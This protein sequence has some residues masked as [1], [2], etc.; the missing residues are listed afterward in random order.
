MYDS[1]VVLGVDIGGSHITAGLVDMHCRQVLQASI[2]RNPVDSHGGQ[3]DILSTWSKTI[4]LAMARSS[5]PIT[6]IGFAMPGPFDYANGICLIDGFDKY[7]SLYGLNIFHQIKKYLNLSEIE[8]LLRNDAEAFLAGELFAG[9]AGE[10]ETAIGITLGT[11]LGSAFYRA[12]ET[13]DAALSVMPYKGDKIEE[14][15]STRGLLRTY[16]ELSGVWL[17]DAKSISDR[18][19][20]DKNAMETYRIFSEDLGWF[21]SRFILNE[22]PEAL[23]IGGNIAK[24]WDFFMDRTLEVIKEQAAV[25]PRILKATQGEYAALIGGACCFLNK[26]KAD[27]IV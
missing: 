6:Q 8:I 26:G 13:H 9:T 12:G 25:L 20:D 23:I 22:S 24:G 5:T 10:V 17:K 14:R 16:Y 21:L 11:G 1:S 19:P 18:I 7:E 3:F 15:V 4:E 2:V 27:K